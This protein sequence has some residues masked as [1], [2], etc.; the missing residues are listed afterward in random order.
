MEGIVSLLNSLFPLL[1]LIQ[2]A[3][4]LNPHIVAMPLPIQV[5]KALR[6]YYASLTLEPDDVLSFAYQ[7]ASGMVSR[8]HTSVVC[9]ILPNESLP[10]TPSGVPS[11]SGHC[12]PGPGQ[13]EHPYD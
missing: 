2:R 7:I 9:D 11:W 4:A 13:Q 12:T 8:D 5:P 3:A 6:S 10:C 1:L